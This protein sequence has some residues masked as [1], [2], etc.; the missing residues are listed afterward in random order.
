[1][2]EPTFT[3][4]GLT[5]IELAREALTDLLVEEKE[6]LDRAIEEDQTPDNVDEFLAVVTDQSLRVGSIEGLLKRMEV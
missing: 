4:V 2:S 6:A 1:M 5:E 3:L